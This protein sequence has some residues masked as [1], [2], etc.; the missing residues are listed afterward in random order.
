[1]VS[2]QYFQFFNYILMLIITLGLLLIIFYF[3]FLGHHWLFRFKVTPMGK[4][5]KK[6]ERRSWLEENKM[7]F[8]SGILSLAVIAAMKH[9]RFF[10]VL[11]LVCILNFITPFIR[12]QIK[13]KVLERKL[14]KKKVNK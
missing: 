3:F 1:M 12:L 14:K 13:I 2:E 5:K 9:E 10:P 8:V 11:I 6:S 4:K 7:Y